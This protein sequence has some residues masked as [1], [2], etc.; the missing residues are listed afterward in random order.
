[1][2]IQFNLTRDDQDPDGGNKKRTTL[3]SVVRSLLGS[4]LDGG[5]LDKSRLPAGFDC[6]SFGG[7]IK[8]PLLRRTMNLD[9][10]PPP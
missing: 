7:I 4:D 6:V 5:N 10:I 9:F 1:M 2:V 3:E 8:G